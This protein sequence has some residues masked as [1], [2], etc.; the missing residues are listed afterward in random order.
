M[1]KHKAALAAVAI[2]LIFAS[3]GPKSAETPAATT[4]ATPTQ[5]SAATAT[6][7][8]L[9]SDAGPPLTDGLYVVPGA[10]PG[11]GCELGA[12]VATKAGALR[13]RADE[14]APVV[15]QISQGENVE[16]LESVLRL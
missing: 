6:T 15:A 4:T 1:T 12:W 16:A 14:T 10:C 5:H 7:V 3:C 9:P 8:G 13:E 11:E 2:C